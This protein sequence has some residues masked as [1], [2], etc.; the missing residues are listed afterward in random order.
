M[1][2][3][4]LFVDATW[5]SL[6]LLFQIETPDSSSEGRETKLF[7]DQHSHDMN[8][9]AHAL[10]TD[11]L[12]YASDVSGLP[13]GDILRRWHSYIRRPA[14]SRPIALWRLQ[15]A[16]FSLHHRTV[17]GIQ[18]SSLVAPVVICVYT[19]NFKCF[20]SLHVTVRGYVHGINILF[21]TVLTDGTY[22]VFLSWRL[23]D[24]DR[25]LSQ[26]WYPWVVR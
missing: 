18:A 14:Y 7:P 17:R 3:L 2:M 22:S 6:A 21:L 15:Y 12:I 23:E 25:L 1:C 13:V 5:D 16:G 20:T 9:T 8:I 24:G 10:T 4:F 19:T 26:R 11:F